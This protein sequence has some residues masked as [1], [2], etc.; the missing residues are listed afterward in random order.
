M[1]E[2]VYLRRDPGD[3]Q[4]PNPLTFCQRALCAGTEVLASA[5][6]LLLGLRPLEEGHP[7]NLSHM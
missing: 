4:D 7:A 6:L 3:M 5:A 2:V 1:R